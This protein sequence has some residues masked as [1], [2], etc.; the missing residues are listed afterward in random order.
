VSSAVFQIEVLLVILWVFK[1]YS[2]MDVVSALHF[3][4]FGC[5]FWTLLEYIFHRFILHPQG[6]MPDGKL[7]SHLTHHSFPNLKNKVALGFFE[8]SLIIAAIALGLSFFLPLLCV[9]LWCIGFILTLICYDAMHYYCHF[10]P[11]I[12][13][14]WLKR[15]RINHLK[16]H[17]RDQQTNFGVTTNFWDKVFGTYDNK[18]KDI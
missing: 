7:S 12:N 13:I 17:Y 10:G 3:A 11:E 6:P 5:I 4:A 9:A 1:H 14:E 15:L 18:L 2:F 8:N 16:H